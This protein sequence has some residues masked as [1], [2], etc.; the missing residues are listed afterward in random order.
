MLDIFWQRNALLTQ[1]ASHGTLTLHLGDRNHV[2]NTFW[3]ILKYHHEVRA[4]GLVKELGILHQ[5]I[6][7]AIASCKVRGHKNEDDQL[8]LI[9]QHPSSCLLVHINP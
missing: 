7:C 3:M 8:I 6:K 5:H 2:C 1:E 4:H 9:C